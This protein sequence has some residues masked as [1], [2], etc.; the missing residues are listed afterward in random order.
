M[1][2]LVELD[3]EVMTR[4]MSNKY[5]QHE[6]L[7]RKMPPPDISQCPSMNKAYFEKNETGIE[8]LHTNRIKDF[9]S[10]T[11][12]KNYC[13]TNIKNKL[14]IVHPRVDEMGMQAYQM[15]IEETANLLR[16]PPNFKNKI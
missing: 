9:K 13:K 4:I 11:Y 15:L 3:I 14:S 12:V 5:D 1:A 10:Q 2:N 6:I 8:Q 7:K 16:S